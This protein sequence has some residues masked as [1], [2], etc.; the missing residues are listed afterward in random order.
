MVA[1]L[2]TDRR[3]YKKRAK[4]GDM[5]YYEYT[6]DTMGNGGLGHVRRH[7]SIGVMSKENA[8]KL[9]KF[10]DDI[11]RSEAQNVQFVIPTAVNVEA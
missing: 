9:Q 3:L 7:S 2:Q 11:H 6:L 10:I 8:A 4:D 1:T 5:V